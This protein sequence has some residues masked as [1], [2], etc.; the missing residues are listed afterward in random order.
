MKIFTQTKLNV[1][2]KLILLLVGLCILHQG[3]FGQESWRILE[4][5]P[6]HRDRAIAFSIDKFGYVANGSNGR[7]VCNDIW[8]FDPSTNSWDS[9]G[10]MPTLGRRSTFCFV[11]SG[12]A[13]V[14]GGVNENGLV[15]KEFWEYDPASNIWERK[16]DLDVGTY[17]GETLKSFSINDKG[18]LL[19]TYNSHNFLEYEVESDTW[20]P[21]NPFPGE[22]TLDQ[23]A[24]SIEDKGYVGTGFGGVENKAEFWEYDPITNQWARKTDFPGK[25]RSAAIGYSIG[26]LG[27]IGHG[28]VRFNDLPADY[29]EYNPLTNSWNQIE[30]HPHSSYYGIGFSIGNKGYVGLGLFCPEGAFWEYTPEATSIDEIDISDN[31]NVFPNPTIDKVFIEMDNHYENLKVSVYAA[32]GELLL[33]KMINSGESVDIS[34]LPPGVYMFCIDKPD[35]TIV[36]KVI[37]SR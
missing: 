23:V 28:M 1:R 21:M 24:F 26:G 19:S 12:K 6:G 3:S 18:Y 10:I 27:Y 29:W 32:Y 7:K 8:R 13:Y 4:R 22:A 34:K 5:F 15:D 37:K 2:L 17:S 9:L 33:S 35:S 30:N 31:V 11:I 20:L 16:A 25:A 14:G 36:K